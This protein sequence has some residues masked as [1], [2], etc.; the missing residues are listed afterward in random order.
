M[1]GCLGICTCPA[2]S[3]VSASQALAARR[4]AIP[5]RLGHLVNFGSPAGPP[6]EQRPDRHRAASS[7]RRSGAVIGS[8]APDAVGARN[9]SQRVQP[10]SDVARPD[11]ILLAGQWLPIRTQSDG[12]RCPDP[13]WISL[14]R[15]RSLVQIQYGP[16]VFSKLCLAAE[17]PMGASHLRIYPIPAGQGGRSRYSPSATFSRLVDHPDQHPR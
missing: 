9:G 7:P 2:H 3:A 11:Q 17:A 8:G 5:R 4:A 15:K 6:P 12:D 13:L 16:R 14:T 10:P 1:C